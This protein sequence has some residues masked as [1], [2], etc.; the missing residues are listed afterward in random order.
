VAEIEG[1][2]NTSKDKLGDAFKA[3][4]ADTSKEEEQ[5]SDSYFTSV[6]VLSTKLL[7]PRIVVPY[8]ENLVSNLNDQALMHQL[9]TRL[10]SEPK[11]NLTNDLTDNFTTRNTSRYDS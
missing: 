2:D 1:E 4:L 7:V 6:K 11:D 10:P 5:H 9:T 3:L 8:V